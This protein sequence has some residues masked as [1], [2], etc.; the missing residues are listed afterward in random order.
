MEH[1]NFLAFAMPAFFIFLFLEYKLIQRRKKPEIFN[2][3]SSVSNISIG[4]A[5]R[6]INLFI[7]ASFYQLYYFIYNNYRLLDI[8][9][10]IFV[11]FALILATDFV[12]YWY[13]RLGHEVNFFW[14]AHI[15]HHHSEE[16]NFT[17]AARITTFQA[18]VRTGFW[19]VLPL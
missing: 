1:I 10:N 5:E 7:A 16:F 18:V 14:A 13:H 11:W 9:S 12:W 4:I 15:V 2:Y 19:C 3:E 6:L 17:A 8:P